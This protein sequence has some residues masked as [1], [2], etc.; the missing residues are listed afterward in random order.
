MKLIATSHWLGWILRSELLHYLL[1]R[2]GDLYCKAP[3]ERKAQMRC[4]SLEKYPLFQ[5]GL[6]KGNDLFLKACYDYWRISKFPKQGIF[7]IFISSFLYSKDL[8]LF[9][10]GFCLIE[11]TMFSAD[12][13][14]KIIAIRLFYWSA[15]FN[16]STH[17]VDN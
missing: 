4:A 14:G 3:Q 6:W 15:M 8:C 2:Q 7:Y 12:H 5:K 9:D 1:A 16:D 17:I 10:R 13:K 11:F